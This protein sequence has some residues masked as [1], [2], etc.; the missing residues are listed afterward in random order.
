MKNATAGSL[1]S[2]DCLI[3][4]SANDKLEIDV[5]SIVLK[6]FGRQIKELINQWAKENKVVGYIT[7][8]DKG[9]LNPTIIARLNTA[10]ARAKGK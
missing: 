10:L 2:N 6:Q 9:A 8:D 4:I 5:K 3:T 1:E 7:I